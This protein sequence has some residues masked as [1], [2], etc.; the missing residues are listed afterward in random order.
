MGSKRHSLTLLLSLNLAGCV[1]G[2][3]YVEPAPELPDRWTA[4]SVEPI[5]V[6]VWWRILGDPQ[7]TELVE[8]SVASNLDLRAALARID[9]ARAVH[10]VTSG[11]L[12]PDVDATGGYSRSENSQAAAGVPTTDFSNF[13]VGLSASWEIDLFG[14]VRRSIEASRADYE[15]VLENYRGVLISL[16]ALVAEAYINVRLN[17]RRIQIARTNFETQGSSL[18][19]VSDRHEGGAASGLDLAQAESNVAS[20]EALIPPLEDALTQSIHRLAVLLDR[21]FNVMRKELEAKAPIPA[22]AVDITAGLPSALL[23][24]R[25]DV[26]GVEFARIHRALRNCRQRFNFACEFH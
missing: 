26:R 14:H 9:E 16:H 5:E 13:D 12:Y 15:Q 1:V 8:Q 21:P 3:D 20:T 19:Y 22:P 6:N 23:R 7:L 24:R 2:P 10:G 4:G 18:N 25:P 17:Q 11:R